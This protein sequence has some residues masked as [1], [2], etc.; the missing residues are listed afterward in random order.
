[1]QFLKR[2][3]YST[4]K[5]NLSPGCKMLCLTLAN[6][7]YIIYYINRLKEKHHIIISID[8]EATFNK[9]KREVF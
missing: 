9:S 5:E 1:M 8:E 6:L 7:F 2:H 4:I 3:Y